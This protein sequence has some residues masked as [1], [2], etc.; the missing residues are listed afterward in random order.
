MLPYKITFGTCTRIGSG[1]LFHAV[2][3]LRKQII[4]KRNFNVNFIKCGQFGINV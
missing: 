1:N 3:D 2:N 4:L